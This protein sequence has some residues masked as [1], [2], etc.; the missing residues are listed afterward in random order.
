MQKRILLIDNYDSFTWNLWYIFDRILNCRTSV[1]RNNEISIEEIGSTRYDGI[2]LSPGPGRPENSGVCPEAI[3]EFHKQIPILGVCLGHQA[4]GLVFGALI[5][6]NLPPVHGK[7]SEILHDQVSLF[8]SIPQHTKVMRYHSLAINR[9]SL[10]PEFITSA[11]TTDG[12]IMGIRHQSYPLEGIQFHPESV[13]TQHGVKMLQ[14]WL[15][16]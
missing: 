2:V 14:N 13:L 1:V 5:E 11:S 12:T 3:R 9:K 15:S 16:V 4:I 10:P 8:D 7:V 6:K